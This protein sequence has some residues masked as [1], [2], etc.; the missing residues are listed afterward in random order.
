MVAKSMYTNS[1]GDV[2][3]DVTEEA[4]WWLGNYGLHQRQAPRGQ[5]WLLRNFR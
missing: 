1:D 4:E 3:F 2:L 5:I